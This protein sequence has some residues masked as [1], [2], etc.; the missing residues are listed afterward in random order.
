MNLWRRK[1]AH[2]VSVER[3]PPTISTLRREAPVPMCLDPHR[4]VGADLVTSANFASQEPTQRQRCVEVGIAAAQA[5]SCIN[6]EAAR[7]LNQ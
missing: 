5:D 2:V 1:P 3:K 6:T 4:I 7:D